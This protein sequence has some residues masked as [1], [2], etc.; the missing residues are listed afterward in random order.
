MENQQLPQQTFDSLKK[1]LTIPLNATNKHITRIILQQVNCFGSYQNVGIVNKG[2]LIIPIVFVCGSKFV[3]LVG[4]SSCS[5]D[6]FP[7]DNVQFSGERVSI[8]YFD[9]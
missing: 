8:G 5:K 2:E 4:L 7:L 3:R 9:F 6:C 1:R